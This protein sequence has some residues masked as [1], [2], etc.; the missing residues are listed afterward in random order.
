MKNVISGSNQMVI[1]I[2][3]PVSIS[4]TDIRCQV[5]RSQKINLRVERSK[6]IV[7]QMVLAQEVQVRPMVR[8]RQKWSFRVE[9]VGLKD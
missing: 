1:R 7:G 5:L 4:I 9:N 2:G 6:W 3:A 8:A